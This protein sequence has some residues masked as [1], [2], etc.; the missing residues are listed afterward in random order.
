MEKEMLDGSDGTLVE[1]SLGVGLNS[2]VDDLVDD[3]REKDS[4]KLE[5][6][7]AQGELDGKTGVDKESDRVGVGVKL[8]SEV[9]LGHGIVNESLQD[10]SETSKLDSVGADDRVVGR[11]VRVEG[12]DAVEL[13]PGGPL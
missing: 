1:D 4:L 6:D 2:E 9:S 13:T 11:G 8:D 7:E 3:G 12:N 10:V 5:D